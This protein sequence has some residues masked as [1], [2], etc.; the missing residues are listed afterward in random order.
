MLFRYTGDNTKKTYFSS[1]IGPQIDMLSAA[2]VQVN[3]QNASFSKFNTTA[4]D[5]Y[6]KTTLDAVFGVGVGINLSK[7]LVLS[8]HLRLDYG[9]GDAE[10]KS[11]TVGGGKLYNS[12]RAATHNAT[13]GALIG[14]T[15]RLTKK[16][17]TTEKTKVIQKTKK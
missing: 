6:K 3:S 4:T 1:F 12:A 2:S 11:V 5:L 8:G 7:N 10:D 14:L 16:A 13:G 15:Y 9:L 17:K